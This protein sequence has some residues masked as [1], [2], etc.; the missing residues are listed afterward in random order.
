[1]CEGRGRE[2]L[3][4]K[5]DLTAVQQRAVASSFLE[6]LHMSSNRCS[7]SARHPH[8]ATVAWVHQ[9]ASARGLDVDQ[10]LALVD[11]MA[12][13]PPPTVAT[14]S[15]HHRPSGRERGAWAL[16]RDRCSAVET[17]PLDDR[18]APAVHPG[19][20]LAHV[21]YH[22][23]RSVDLLDRLVAEYS[24]YSSAL[25]AQ[26]I[27]GR[28][29]REDLVQV[30]VEGLLEA[31]TRFEPER[32]IP[33]IA[34]ARP[35]IVGGLKRHYRDRGWLVRVP[36]SVHETAVALGPS[37]EEVRRETGRE[38]TD[39]EIAKRLN[40]S[41]HHLERVRQAIAERATDSL[42]REAA[43]TPGGEGRELAR[44]ETRIALEQAL[45]TVDR[46]QREVLRLYFV[47]RLTQQE[48]ADRLGVNQMRVSRWIRA[49][50]SKLRDLID[51][52]AQAT[53]T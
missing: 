4:Q 21:T 31:L 24:S 50:L 18:G 6:T 40:I 35:T 25:A 32:R 16:P 48:I 44:A 12:S 27:R 8:V 22:R 3:G 28:E 7:S 34:F 5:V 37:T 26:F 2:V 19:L 20:W 15:F 46:Q 51:E 23:S 1:M 41:A 38:P 53:G 39:A 11:R 47:D 45:E 49:T 52:P 43:P 17:V 33:F 10:V 29:P 42:D 36:R 13:A 9:V 30:A 14:D